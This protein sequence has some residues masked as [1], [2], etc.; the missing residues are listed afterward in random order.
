MRYIQI[1]GGTPLQGEIEISGGKNAALA[2]IA[3]SAL[4][5]NAV[6]LENIP[7]VADVFVAK[8]ILEALGAKVGMPGNG[9]MHIDPTCMTNNEVPET[10]SSKMR[11][12]YYF[13]SVLLARFGHGVVAMPGGCAI[14]ERPVDQTVKG[15]SALGAQVNADFGKLEAKGT[16]LV[17]SEIYMD[18]ASVGATINTDRKSTRLNSSH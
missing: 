1:Q 13:C 8:D 7:Y 16:T 9:R 2:I 18:C 5:Q 15:L 17:G 11:A 3:A 4:S 12:S 6:T 14:G 10:L